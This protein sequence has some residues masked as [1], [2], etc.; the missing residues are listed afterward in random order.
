MGINIS[1]PQVIQAL[2]LMN[3]NVE[4]VKQKLRL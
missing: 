3:I 1:D 4:A 2:E